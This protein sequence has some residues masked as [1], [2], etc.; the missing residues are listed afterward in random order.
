ME[1]SFSALIVNKVNELSEL[2]ED[3]IDCIDCPCRF[4]KKIL[5][6]DSCIKLLNRM[7]PG[8]NIKQKDGSGYIRCKD[9]LEEVKYYFIY[10]FDDILDLK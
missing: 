10:S 7:Y 6:I 4:L 5:R 8:M 2:H 9:I 3:D 1:R